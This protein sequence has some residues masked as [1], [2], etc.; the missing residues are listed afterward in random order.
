MYVWSLPMAFHL[1]V[2]LL[3]FECY[4]SFCNRVGNFFLYCDFSRCWHGPPLIP[5]TKMTLFYRTVATVKYLIFQKKRI[6][7]PCEL[8]EHK[9]AFLLT[10]IVV[11]MSFPRL[12]LHDLPKKV[13]IFF[14]FSCVCWYSRLLLHNMKEISLKTS[15]IYYSYN[16]IRP[17]Q[18]VN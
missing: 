8:F 2:P 14:F 6:H 7:C 17:S 12:L 10:H 5:H 11:L 1:F 4:N 9:E 18:L 13:F 3:Y 16:T 15:N